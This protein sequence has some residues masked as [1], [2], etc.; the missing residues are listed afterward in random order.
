M[1]LTI[2]Q[3]VLSGGLK[4]VLS[5]VSQRS[6]LPVLGNVLLQAEAD[7][8]VICSTDLEI[9]IKCALPALVEQVGS[10]TLPA[11]KFGQ[12][13]SALPAGDV[14]LHTD[15]RQHTSITCKRSRFKIA[16]LDANEFPPNEPSPANWSFNMPGIAFKK[17]LGKVSYSR[18]AD[19]NRQVLNG[20][21]LSV[22]NGS[23]TAA[24]TDGKRMALVETELD[25]QTVPDGDVILPPK[26]V[27]ELEKILDG[28][29]QMAASFSDTQA[30]FAQNET[31]VISKLIDG[32]YP[33]YRQ[34]IPASFANSVTIPREVF[35]DV[36]N[37]VAMVVTE[38]SMSVTFKL[39]KTQMTVSAISNEIGESMEPM[40][41]AYEG[42][43]IVISFN[44]AFIIEPVRNL[45]ADQLIMQFNDEFSP[46]CLS[47]D[48]G[49]IYILMPMRN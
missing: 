3:T 22:R 13:V 14:L 11:R 40:E 49:F 34:V 37:R 4:K 28:N 2:P 30:I 12:I 17:I 32:V 27:G 21:L 39:E 33:N 46:V 41:V 36:L 26:L 6:T 8:L 25:G 7:K 1:K 20:I 29:G 47:G 48:E 44:P 10:T 31:V 9:Y 19:E 42:N 43:D 15:E 45:E 18:S 5:V 24:A 35:A 38:N 16:G 23:L